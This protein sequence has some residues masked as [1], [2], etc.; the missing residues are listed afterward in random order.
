M[1]LLHDYF[2]FDTIKDFVAYAFDLFQV[3]NGSEILVFAVINYRLCL[4]FTDTFEGFKLFNAR[5]V[6]IY[7]GKQT[8]KP[9]TQEC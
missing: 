6:D 1:P 3:V 5:C 7:S 4:A 9:H 2:I 8:A